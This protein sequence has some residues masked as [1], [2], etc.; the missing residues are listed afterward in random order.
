MADV[1]YDPTPITD[2][3]PT[4][5]ADN[6]PSQGGVGQPDNVPTAVGSIPSTIAAEGGPPAAAGPPGPNPEIAAEISRLIASTQPQPV[7]PTLAA[8][9][10][11]LPLIAAT[12]TGATGMGAEGAAFG[13]NQANQLASQAA[14]RK[15]QQQERVAIA[16]KNLMEEQRIR[17]KEQHDF[18][19]Q[20]QAE[21]KIK[22]AAIKEAETRDRQQRKDAWTSISTPGGVIDQVNALIDK[23]DPKA[24]DQYLNSTH[25]GELSDQGQKHTLADLFKE[26]A[27][28]DPDGQ[29]YIGGKVKSQKEVLAG[30][31]EDFVLQ[32]EEAYRRKTGRP[33]TDDERQQVDKAAI[34]EYNGLNKDPE[35]ADL[36]DAI[37]R[38]DV[39]LKTIQVSQLRQGMAD[40]QK[41]Q[42]EITTGT[43]AWKRAN[44]LAHGLI[45]LD[46]FVKLHPY[47]RGV[48]AATRSKQIQ[49]EYDLAREINPDFS[50]ELF[51][52]GAK[53]AGSV[54]TRR[55]M[56]AI[57]TV[58]A[59]LPSIEDASDHAIRSNIKSLNEHLIIPGGVQIGAHEYSD[60][61]AARKAFADE[62]S[63]ALGT[64]GMSDFRLQ[65]G[66]DL[67]DTN[68]SPENFRSAMT[69]I[70]QFL[71]SKER[72]LK[73][74]MGPYALQTGSDLL[75]PPKT[76]STADPLG[77]R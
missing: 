41:A 77:I 27:V 47:E 71:G 24:V 52:Q 49:Q 76:G 58:R 5:G 64:S 62:L 54:Q 23:G 69:H 37:K 68:L 13:M 50:P 73:S 28:K 1:P 31:K 43:P 40:A 74:Q 36:N 30:S 4:E 29:H 75:N 6:P 65:Y 38:L 44:D 72:G 2:A 53:F 57:A 21:A 20:Q 59:A 14:D 26:F 16:I 7:N 19:L 25:V 22:A 9:K 51:K 45:S 17:E 66:V 56:A 67:A 33:I 3:T 18:M 46:D 39:Q 42:G 11:A 61:Q 10:F 60:L 8:L 32:A 63:L 15:A 35:S 12:Y 48:T 70:E 55:Q 34:K